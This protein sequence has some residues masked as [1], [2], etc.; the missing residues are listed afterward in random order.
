MPEPG[1]GTMLAFARGEIQKNRHGRADHAGSSGGTGLG[2]GH[3]Q[4]T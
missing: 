3:R 4:T 1:Y 2:S